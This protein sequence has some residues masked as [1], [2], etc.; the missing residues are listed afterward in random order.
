MTVM[1]ISGSTSKWRAPTWQRVIVNSLLIL[2]VVAMHNVL[3][4]DTHS[5]EGHHGASMASSTTATQNTTASDT[6]LTQSSDPGV[7][8]SDPMP[9]CGGAMALCLAMILG[10]SA[11][12]VI[13]KRL[14]DRVLWQLPPPV[15]FASI[16]PCPPFN[17]RSPL[18][19]S[20]IL[21]C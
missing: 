17:S 13:R 7:P 18:Q 3:A 6:L 20:S 11:Y 2:G 12:I 9:D 5:A 1:L 16:A 14:A 8:P 19:R 21:R 4:G 10:I 15:K